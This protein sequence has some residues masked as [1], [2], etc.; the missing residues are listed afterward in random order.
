MI[1]SFLPSAGAHGPRGTLEKFGE[2]DAARAFDYGILVRLMGFLTPYR[3]RMG[4][5][6]VCMMASSALT[7]LAPYLV[8]VAI[9]TNI[10]GLDSPGLARTAVLIGLSFVGVYVTTSGQGYL[11][12]WV[13]QRMLAALRS[14]LFRKLQV[15]SM[16]YHDTH[17]VGVTISRVINDVAVINE[18]LSEGIV[19]LI[20]DI[21]VLV[22][23]VA[24]MVSMNARLAL[25]TFGVMPLMVV[26]TAVF[27]RHARAAFR[28]TRA[29]VAAVIGDLAEN[30]GGMRVI[31]AFSQEG[32]TQ[33]KFDQVNSE[34]RDAHVSAMSLSF[35]FIPTVEFLGILATA[36]VLLFG[37]IAVTRGTMTLGVVVAF[38]SYVSR[39]FEP[40]QELSQLYTTL[41]AA[42]AGGEQVLKLMDTAPQ[43]QDRERATEVG[44]LRGL[45]EFQEV[46]FTYTGRETVLH[47]ADIVVEPGQTAAFVGPTGAGK[48]TI[49]SLIA[50][51]YDVSSGRI[52]VDGID[53]RDISQRSLRRQMGI[54]TQDPF[55][56]SGTIRDNIRFAQPRSSEEDVIKAAR[57]AHAHDFI[58]S[59]PEKYDTR[60][61]EGGVNLSIGQRQLISISRAI[62]AD[63]RILVLDEATSSVDTVTEMLIQEALRALLSGRTAIVIAH[64]LSTIVSADIIYVID[65]GRVVDRGA[66]RDLLQRGGLYRDLYERQFL[67]TE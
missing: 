5:A 58:S 11:I 25:L 7:I 36:V 20:G 9:D 29:R 8:K 23:I 39:F 31:Q 24:V 17:I 38:L 14:E 10:S 43:V 27:T 28:N 57:V 51:F 40:I 33:G 45:I 30:I 19:R 61:L 56:F 16:A 6:L 47:Q 4:L 12:S 63:P 52:L 53:V 37:G 35:I 48:T 62:C 13:G 59:L 49:A 18:L 3:G 1:G 2:K 50:R 42:M 21:V 44:E 66:H 55:L 60:I 54:V 46:D 67:R 64:R 22:G 26:A 34:N 15:F 65:G 41:Q 32:A